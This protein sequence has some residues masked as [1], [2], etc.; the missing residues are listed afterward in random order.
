[1]LDFG[2][3]LLPSS[4][5]ETE[6]GRLLIESEY[7]DAIDALCVVSGESMI[8]EFKLPTFLDSVIKEHNRIISYL[9]GGDITN[10]GIVGGRSAG[11]LYDLPISVCSASANV[12]GAKKFIDSL[13]DL[14]YLSLRESELRGFPL[15][16]SV[17]DNHYEYMKQDNQSHMSVSDYLKIRES[18]PYRLPPLKF[19]TPETPEDAL[20]FA[21]IWVPYTDE[22]YAELTEFI[23]T[24][25]VQI[26]SS[27][28]YNP[29]LQSEIEAMFAGIQDAE[30][31]AKNIQKR[32]TIYLNEQK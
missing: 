29:I 6:T 1:M 19:L 23:D 17:L 15:K 31:T 14:D 9:V 16:R 10:I 2:M 3:S 8:G 21:D 32:Y 22:M 11:C 24:A 26:E 12:D 7:P 27:E 4:T 20:V 25:S 18:E 28:H 13:W 30:T 5:K